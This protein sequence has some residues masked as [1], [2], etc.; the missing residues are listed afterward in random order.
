MLGGS[1]SFSAAVTD[2]GGDGIC[3]TSDDVTTATNGV[4]MGVSSFA[5]LTRARTFDADGDGFL[6]AFDLYWSLAPSSPLSV[7]DVSVRVDS[8]YASGLSHPPSLTSSGKLA[9]IDGQFASWELPRVEIRGNA[10]F[11]TG[12]YYVG[13]VEDGAAPS[14]TASVP[15]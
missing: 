14:I 12:S 5:V 15:A 6:D 11:Q 7:S 4:T 2:C 3:G 1:Y 13:V 9:F 10:H 8:R